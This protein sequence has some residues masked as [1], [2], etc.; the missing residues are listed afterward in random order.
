MIDYIA[1]NIQQFINAAETT[2]IGGND[3]LSGGSGNDILIGAGGNDY[4]NGGTGSDQLYG[5]AG[6]DVLIYDANDKLDGGTG[7]DEVRIVGG[8]NTTIY[9]NSSNL[10]QVERI[11]LS[12]NSAND[13]VVLSVNDVIRVSDDDVMIITGDNGDDVDASGFTKFLGY[14][15]HSDGNVYGAY[16]NSSETAYL[17]IERG[18]QLNGSTV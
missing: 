10:S 6:N 16:T 7:I 13:K 3:I 8:G 12:D 14:T 2:G 11:D 1:N 17:M 5:G 15:T 9:L 4:L 18:L